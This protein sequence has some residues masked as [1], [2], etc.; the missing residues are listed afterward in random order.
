M[1]LVPERH[2]PYKQ[3]Y[4]HYGRFLPANLTRVFDWFYYDTD[5]TENIVST[6]ISLRNVLYVH[7][8]NITIGIIDTSELLV[9]VSDENLYLIFLYI[10][11]IQRVYNFQ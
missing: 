6:L 11:G 3:I 10:F 7:L 8:Y 4:P 9:M 5:T 1:S 2:Y